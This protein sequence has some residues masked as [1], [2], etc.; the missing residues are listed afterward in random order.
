MKIKSKGRLQ[1]SIA[2]FHFAPLLLSKQLD[3]GTPI[4]EYG[5]QKVAR[6][7]SGKA[8]K[9]EWRHMKCLVLLAAVALPQ[10]FIHG[11]FWRSADCAAGR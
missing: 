5:Y 2:S 3:L 7:E 10:G 6:R 9:S 11:R 1:V 4:A 8:K